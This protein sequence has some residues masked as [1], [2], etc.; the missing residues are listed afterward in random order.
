MVFG[1]V[2]IRGTY[3]RHTWVA[4]AAAER[5]AYRPLDVPR[6]A[7]RY[8]TPGVFIQDDITVASWLSLSA[9]ARA[10]FQNQ[11]GTFFSPRVSALLRWQGWTSR[12]SAG[13]GFFAP[14]PLTE[15]TEAAGLSRLSIPVPLVAER[16][17]STAVDLTRNL[18]PVSLTT[19]FFA[20]AVRHP[21]HVERGVR[22]QITNQP[23]SADNL[24]VEFLG[25][26]RKAPF[27]ATASYTYV[28]SREPEGG[29]RVDTP[30][31]PQQ[32]FGLVGMWEKGDVWRLGVECYY[33][34]R[35]RLE[36]NPYR[37][38]SRPYVLVGFLGE[39]RIGPVRL[40]VNVENLGGV[41]QT[42]WDPL[43]RPDRASDGRWTVDAWAPL[44]GRVL[45]GGV[46]FRF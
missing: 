7:Y 33:T 17:R 39:R 45:N 24:G 35:Q 11:Y 40:F 1:E 38:E 8:T 36:E 9:S 15:E 44:D 13:Q 28:N 10:D 18:G 12:V 20:S 21:I 19:T 31:T 6:F 42:R 29:R 4:G 3:G 14:T 23:G 27:S 30:L 2:S 41:R 5:E 26:W 43:L 37:S 34:G 16:G 22:Y 32:S 46:R 25:T